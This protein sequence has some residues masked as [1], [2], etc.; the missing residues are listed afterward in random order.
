M[1]GCIL[2]LKRNQHRFRHVQRHDAGGGGEGDQTGT[3][4]EGDADRES[5]CE[6]PPVPT[7][8][9]SSRRFSQEWMTPSPGRSEMPPRLAMKVG[10]SR[11]ILTSTSFG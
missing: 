8:S 2:P 6:S 1:P 5:G 11:C 3:G 10:S 7:V 4:G 9:G